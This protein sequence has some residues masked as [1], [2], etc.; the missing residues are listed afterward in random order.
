MADLA[1]RL[2]CADYARLAPLR[3]SGPPRND[4]R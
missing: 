2:A 3:P 4:E 1:I